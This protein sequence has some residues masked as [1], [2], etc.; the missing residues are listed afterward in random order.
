MEENGFVRIYPASNGA[1][2][3]VCKPHPH[4]VIHGQIKKLHF[5]KIYLDNSPAIC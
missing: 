1:H 5:F 2:I 4:K 3:S